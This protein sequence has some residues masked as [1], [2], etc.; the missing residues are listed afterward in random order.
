MKLHTS[1][2]LHKTNKTKAKDKEETGE[3]M[4]WVVLIPEY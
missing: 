1:K 4:P 3:L 2:Q